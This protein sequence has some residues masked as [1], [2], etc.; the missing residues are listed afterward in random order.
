[1]EEKDL[2]E[3]RRVTWMVIIVLALMALITLY[4]FVQCASGKK[5]H[6]KW[7]KTHVQ[8]IKPVQNNVN[9]FIFS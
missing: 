9:T 8:M 3:G 5:G 1:M 6:D 2:K 7:D 4:E